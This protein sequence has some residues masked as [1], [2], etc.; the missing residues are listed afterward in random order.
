MGLVTTATVFWL[1][2]LPS[3][4]H[5]NPEHPYLGIL[6]FMILPGVFFAGLALMPVGTGL[7][8]RRARKAGTFP[9]K[10]P[11]LDFHNPA[12]R[13][14]V[15]FLGVATFANIV[16]ASQLT[17]RAVT[18]MDSVAFCGTTCHTVMQPEYAAYQNSPHSRVEC[19]RCHIGP[20]ADWFVRSKLSGVRQLFAVSLDTFSRPIPTPVHNLRPARET[21]EACH[22]PQKYGADRLR[23][24]DV[25]ASDEKNTRSKNVLLV[26]I[27]GGAR[28][29]GI[30]GAH[31]ADGVQI[32]YRA[33]DE[34]RQRITWV[35]YSRNG[36]QRRLYLAEGATEEKTKGQE[37]RL[38]D[39]MDCH[40][41]PSHAFESPEVAVNR[42]L[43]AG[44][45]P[46]SLPFAK[47]KALELLQQQ[48][49]S[50]E[51]AA[52]RITEQWTAYYQKE[53]RE[54]YAGKKAEVDRA[55]QAVAAIFN[56][57]VFPAMKVGWG[58]YPNNIGHNDFPGCFRCHDERAE[59]GGKTITQDC[60]TCHSLLAMEES[61]PKILSD[62]GVQ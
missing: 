39:C 3:T 13:R 43:A 16:I 59:A 44:S 29:P 60:S 4:W 23:V 40:N 38:M 32:R 35:E 2:L 26:R 14:L 20:G 62:L 12:L 21:C 9:Q 58:T 41:R 25:F 24:T 28:G 10:L 19:T 31:L 22:W 8:L 48:Y 54:L 47:M 11:P 36:G 1:F 18:Y 27:G 42:A 49:A 34:Q 46:A 57:N 53:H 6:S 56:R 33:S 55:G 37:T 61:D 50:N 51:E 17:Y 52:A 7:R 15:V 45:L 5:G 30:H